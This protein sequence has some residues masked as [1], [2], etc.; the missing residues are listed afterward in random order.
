MPGKSAYQHNINDKI[1]ELRNK[2]QLLEGDRR[3]YYERSQWTMKQNQ[4][5]I[6]K[7][8]KENKELHKMKADRLAV[9]IWLALALLEHLCL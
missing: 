9:S 7:L 5:K 8:R 4:Q 1:E 6:Q 2:I 3:A